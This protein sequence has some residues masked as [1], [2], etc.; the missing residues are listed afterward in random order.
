MIRSLHLLVI[1]SLA[2]VLGCPSVDNAGTEHDNVCIDLSPDGKTLVFSSADGD[3]YLY[4]I[5]E[6][7]AT[8][9]T[10]SDRIESY[11]SFSPDGKQIA[12]AAKENDSALSHVFVLDLDDHSISE[13]TASNEQSDILPRFTADGNRIVFAR[14]YRHRP[15]SLGGWKWDMWDVCSV[16]T[17]GSGLSRLTNEGYYQLFRVVPL[18]DGTCVYAADTIGLDD[19]LPAALYTVSLGNQPTRII[20]KAGTSDANVNAWALDPMVGPDGEMMAYCSDRSKPFWYDV[21][22]EIG[23]AKSKSLVGSKSRYNRYPDFFPDGQ[24]IVFLAGTDFNAGN[25]PVYCLW[26]VSLSGQT[27]ELATSD[28]FTNPSNWLIPKRAEPSAAIESR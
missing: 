21:S 25:R 13:V 15:Y 20:P 10:D 9:L 3:L 11:P 7:T 24:R 26:E 22:V 27:Q 2:L 19:D 12:F 23:D 5:L 14:S 1:A 18:N 16:G 17:D 6:S 4:D 28:L 8:R